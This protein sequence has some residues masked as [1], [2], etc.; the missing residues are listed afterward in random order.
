[1]CKWTARENLILGLPEPPVVSAGRLCD[2]PGMRWDGGPCWP[3]SPGFFW[4]S[5]HSLGPTVNCSPVPSASAP[6]AENER[7]VAHCEHTAKPHI[8]EQTAFSKN[9]E[10]MFSR[11]LT[12]S[13]PTRANNW[14][15]HAWY[16]ETLKQN[17]SLKRRTAHTNT[18]DDYASAQT[19]DYTQE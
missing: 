12:F 17:A 7:H 6:P 4:A 5:C 18:V 19:Y 3:M 1:M 14:I 15:K 13:F 11:I 16:T 9:I 8:I 2:R 10:K